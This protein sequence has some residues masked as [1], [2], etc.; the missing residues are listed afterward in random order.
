[1]APFKHVSRGRPLNEEEAARYDRLRKQAE[2][3]KIGPTEPDELPDRLI[4]VLA[5]RHLIEQLRAERE[6]QC[7][8][9]AA[10]AERT[11]INLTALSRLENYRNA[12]PTIATLARYARALGQELEFRMT[13]CQDE[14]VTPPVRRRPARPK[15]GGNRQR[16]A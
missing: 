3:K 2:E 13:P 6:R 11:K 15:N 12:N 10:V 4:D 1:M 16:T 8:S 7:L 14:V 5:L 9:L